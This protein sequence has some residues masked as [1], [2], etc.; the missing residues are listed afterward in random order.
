M[1]LAFCI[2][3]AGEISMG[4]IHFLIA[5]VTA[6]SSLVPRLPPRFVSCCMKSG[7]ISLGT[8]LLFCVLST[9]STVG[10]YNFRCHGNGI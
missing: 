9:H 6:Y 4:A 5:I 7:E 3:K 1:L 10:L 8:R 2:V